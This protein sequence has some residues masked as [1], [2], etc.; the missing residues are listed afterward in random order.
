MNE[1]IRQIG[2]APV[3]VVTVNTAVVGTGAAGYNA[4]LRVK[5]GGQ[6][7]VVMVTEGVNMGT[8]RNTGSD[9]QT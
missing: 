7:D 1:T 2:G 5:S 4:A 8:S 6:D 3:R 9:K